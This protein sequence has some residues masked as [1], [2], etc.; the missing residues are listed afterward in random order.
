MDKLPGV[1]GLA[2]RESLIVG[3]DSK[4]KPN[5]VEPAKT[6]VLPSAVLAS[7]PWRCFLSDFS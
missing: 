2:P 1:T 7:L 6:T 5:E 4:L 3:L